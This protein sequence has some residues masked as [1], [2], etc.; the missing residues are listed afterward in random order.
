MARGEC[1]IPKEL[2][3]EQFPY[4]KLSAQNPKSELTDEEHQQIKDAVQEMA[5]AASAHLAEARDRQGD[6]PSHARPCLL[7]VVP[8]LHYLSRLE[9][10]EYDI[11]NDGLLEPEQLKVL[12]L[13]GRT[14]MTGIF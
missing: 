1:T 8:A 13:L 7:P 2:L 4:H 14:W 10:T 3:P 11:F 12:L 9:T 5:M 6:L